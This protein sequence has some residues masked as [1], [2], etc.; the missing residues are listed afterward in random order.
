MSEDIMDYARKRIRESGIRVVHCPEFA[1]REDVDAF[2]RIAGQMSRKGA[3][4]RHSRAPGMMNGE[5]SAIFTDIYNGFWMRHRDNLPTL[6]DEAGW[7]AIYA[8]AERLTERYDSPLARD[9]VA[10]LIVIMD[11]RARKENWNGG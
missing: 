5:V 9:M 4:V 10:D 1:Y 11:Q 8:E 3:E 7:D 2:I 6:H